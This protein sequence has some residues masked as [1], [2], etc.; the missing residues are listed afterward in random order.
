MNDIKLEYLMTYH[1]DLKEPLNIGKGPFGNRAIYDVTG[2]YFE[3]PKLRGTLVPSGADWILVGEDGMGRLDVRASFITDDGASIYL[4]YSGL[5][6]LSKIDNDAE[7]EP[8]FGDV[9]F[10]TNPRFETG[11]P[12]Y[13]WLNRLFVVGQGRPL[14]NAVEY[15]LFAINP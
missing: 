7:K 2:G 4:Q 8:D 1:A 13:D 5:L 11:D 3:G 14:K 6:D 12:R 10:F 15:R 9:Y